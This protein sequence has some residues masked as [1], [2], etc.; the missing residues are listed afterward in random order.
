MAAGGENRWP[1]LGRNRWPL[2]GQPFE[3]ALTSR[4]LTTHEAIAIERHADRCPNDLI[5]HSAAQPTAYSR[6]IRAHRRGCCPRDCFRQLASHASRYRFGDE[7]GVQIAPLPRRRRRSDSPR[8]TSA[9]RC[10]E[11]QAVHRHE[12]QRR[13]RRSSAGGC[14]RSARNSAAPVDSRPV[15]QQC[16][17]HE[18]AA[19]SS[20]E[21]SGTVASALGRRP[22]QAAVPAA[23]LVRR[24]CGNEVRIRRDRRDRSVAKVSLAS[25]LRLEISPLRRL[26]QRTE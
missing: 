20:A 1:Y 9:T 23:P 3:L 4:A 2:T 8:R 13:H 25:R 18:P 12:R 6:L 17:F 14:S 11:R 24:Q 15:G 16:R 26:R 10:T 7:G 21:T 19:T 5:A 22:A